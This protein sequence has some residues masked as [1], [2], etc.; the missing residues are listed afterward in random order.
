MPIIGISNQIKCKKKR[1]CKPFARYHESEMI[2]AGKF[3]I[4]IFL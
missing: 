3:I 4:E 2:H 1:R